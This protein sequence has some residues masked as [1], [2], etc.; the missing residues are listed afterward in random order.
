MFVTRAQWAI[1]RFRTLVMLAIAAGAASASLAADADDVLAA[2]LKHEIVGDE[3][4]LAEVQRFVERR[5]PK[6]Q[7]WATA[8]EWQ[9]EAAR[10]RRAVLDNIVFRGAAAAWRDAA[11]SVE[12]LETIEGGLGYRIKKLRYQALPGMWI[13]GLLYE[14]EKIAGRVPAVLNVNGHAGPVGKQYPP[15][16]LRCI[17][18]AKRGM[19]AL[20][21]EWV[22]M[23]QLST[24]GFAHARMNQLDLCGASGLAPFYLNM[25][26]GLDLLLSL[27]HTD[28]QRVAVTGLS[29]GGW[30]T[31][32][33]SALDTRVSL[34]NPVAGY[35]SFF[36][37]ARQFK[38][39]GDSEQTP[40]D[41]ATLVDYT[42]L[43]AMLAPRP[44]LLTYNSKDNC[45]FESGYALPPLLD[46]AQP[47]FALFDRAASLRW[48]VNDD[49][50][51]H[52]FDVDNRQALYRM[53]GD[54]FFPD[55]ADFD[56]REIAS[57]DEI[58]TAE[59]LDVALPTPNQ[60]F[61]SLALA[62]SRDLPR[63]DDP[64]PAPAAAT[65]WRAE[66]TSRLRKVVRAK[67][68]TVT[69]TEVERDS[70][71]DVTAIQW[72]LLVDADWTLPA[73]ELA[74]PRAQRTA[75]VVADGGRATVAGPAARL[76]ADGYRVIALD[77]A[78]V[79]EARLRVGPWLFPVLVAAVG[80]RPLGIQASQIAAAARWAAERH[81]G[82]VTLVSIG[83]RSGV[84]VQLAAAL[85]GDAIAG[86]ELHDALGSLKEALERDWTVSDAPEM[87]CFGLLECCDLRHL[88]ALVSPRPVRFV[89]PSERVQR[90]LQGWAEWSPAN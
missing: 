51:T 36:T 48:H 35:S 16:Q 56:A 42:H 39:L 33:L 69:A 80:E 68:S 74:G 86:L 90:E 45:C 20:N 11:T 58:K 18:L 83:P 76:M 25:K 28:P 30:Q 26:R 65:R 17:N 53:I 72:R 77:P 71:A 7:T 63:I 43:T 79:G 27:E 2:L 84:R 21:I 49:P 85:E 70:R 52:N 1:P 87:F 3:L 41:L 34:S 4:P 15:K 31:I 89:N 13:P 5:I 6:M 32:V 60:D 73:V 59:Q 75:L 24:G 57:D 67:D 81:G 22:G 88:A 55:R 10:L 54:F 61:H 62:L 40:N 19:L 66:L 50:G 23:G 37:R 82:P 47:T 12:W 38:D 9:A 44:T 29:G 14:P 46:A 78:F 8:Q 64:P